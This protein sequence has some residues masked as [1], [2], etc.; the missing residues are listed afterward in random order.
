MTN[1]QIKR[2]YLES[3]G[4]DLDESDAALMDFARNLLAAQTPVPQDGDERAAFEAWGA[5]EYANS[6]VPDNAWIGWQARAALASN[7]AAA[8][9]SD[10]TVQAWAERHDIKLSGNDLRAA[11][12][13]AA[14]LHLIGDV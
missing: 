11:F 14:S 12:E 2:I 10:H 7:K 3:T 5:E 6:R 1:D 9:F 4:F 8:H 13:D